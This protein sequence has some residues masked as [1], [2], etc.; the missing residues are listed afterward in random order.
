MEQKHLSNDTYYLSAYCAVVQNGN[1]CYIFHHEVNLKSTSQWSAESFRRF[2]VFFTIVSFEHYWK[3]SPWS[4]VLLENL[5]VTHLAKKL[6]AFYGT[7]R[8]STVSKDPA[9]G[10]YPD[11]N[12]SRE[13]YLLL[14]YSSKPP[15]WKPQILQMNLVHITHILFLYDLPS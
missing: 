10:L 2:K 11:P 14:G 6:S 9:T 5:I 12:E 13:E 15:L 1:S 3:S 7:R 4:R 8:L